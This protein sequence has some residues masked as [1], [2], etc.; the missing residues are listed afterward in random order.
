MD[1]P[2]TP[3]TEDDGVFQELDLSKVERY[4]GRGFFQMIFQQNHDVN[5][6]YAKSASS[7]A[8]GSDDDEDDDT[9]NAGV[10]IQKLEKKKRVIKNSEGYEKEEEDYDYYEVLGLEKRWLSTADDIR[11]R[12]RSRNIT[13]TT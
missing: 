3:L 2:T 8:D 4:I 12:R 13:L 5:N 11:T 7:N 9:I 6:K 1:T 10:D